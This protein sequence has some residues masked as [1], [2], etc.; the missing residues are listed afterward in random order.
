MYFLTDSP[1]ETVLITITLVHVN[2]I[3]SLCF[4]VTLYRI[5][6]YSVTISKLPI[7]C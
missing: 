5:F 6:L 3:V 1:V 4:I 7:T 2:K